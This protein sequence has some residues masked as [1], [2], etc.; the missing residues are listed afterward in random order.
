MLESIFSVQNAINSLSA[1]HRFSIQFLFSFP[2]TTAERKLYQYKIMTPRTRSMTCTHMYFV[3]TFRL[4]SKS[5]MTDDLEDGNTLVNTNSATIS[6]SFWN[7]R[8]VLFYLSFAL[9]SQ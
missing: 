7:K 3:A 8:L 9:S 1:T 4:F 2:N 5:E 6:L